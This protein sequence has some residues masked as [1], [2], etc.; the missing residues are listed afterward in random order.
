MAP[1]NAHRQNAAERSIRTFKNHFIA[2]L[3]AC[4]PDFPGYLW[5][6]LLEQAEITLNSVR[7]SNLHPQLSAYATV[8]G[9][10][11]YNRHPWLHWGRDAK[12]MSNPNKDA[13]GRHIV[14]KD[15]T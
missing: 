10:F 13:L 6:M 8:N 1:P 11:D 12:S 5:N 15:G 14:Y 7:A 4:D 2:G 9:N 3:A